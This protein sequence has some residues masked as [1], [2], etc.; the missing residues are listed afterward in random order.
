MPTI[1]ASATDRPEE[2]VSETFRPALPARFQ[3]AVE[4][5]DAYHRQDPNGREHSHATRVL[6][7]ILTL[8]PDASEALRLAGRAQ[9]IGRWRIPRDRYPRDRPGYLRWRKD[10]QA[11]HADEAGAILAACGYEPAFVGRVRDIIRKRNLRSDPE[12]QTVEDALCLVFMERQLAGFQQQHDEAKLQR[13]IRRTWSK[14][15][16][17]GQ[18]AALGLPLP[19][20][21]RDL[22]R[23]S[24]EGAG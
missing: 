5:I 11:F 16:P 18:Q 12:I 14:M 4:D 3:R 23:R 7:W 21:V 24:L 9:H 10:L 6:E 15:S 20:E 2:A 19:P 22:L 17:E 13:I 8:R 1:P